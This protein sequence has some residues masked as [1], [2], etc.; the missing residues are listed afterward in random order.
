ME[1][2]RSLL[3]FCCSNCAASVI[4]VAVMCWL[5]LL[6][7]FAAVVVIAA[8]MIKPCLAHCVLIRAFSCSIVRFAVIPFKISVAFLCSIGIC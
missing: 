5:L 4:A 1:F 6:S 2:E 8:G 7:A 3:P